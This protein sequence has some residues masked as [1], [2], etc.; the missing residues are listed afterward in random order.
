MNEL[1]TSALDINANTTK[2]AI[3]NEQEKVKS[4]A[5]PDKVT[6]FTMQNSEFLYPTIV[7]VPLVIV[8]ISLMAAEISL[9][10]KIILIT[11]LIISLTAYIMQFKKVNIEQ[12]LANLGDSLK[13]NLK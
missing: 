6:P 10:T 12:P 1:L 2:Q 3:L 5:S 11:F 8:I 4:A 13:K 7:T 9:F